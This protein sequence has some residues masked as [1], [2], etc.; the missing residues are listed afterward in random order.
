[1]KIIRETAGELA[2]QE[3]GVLSKIVG[4]VLMAGGVGALIFTSAQWWI[5]G[6][7]ALFG[8]AVLLLG[9]V[10]VI[11]FNKGDQKII[12]ERKSL[13]RASHDE[14]NFG[15]VQ[16]FFIQERR[17]AP[18]RTTGRMTVTYRLV[19]I[20]SAGAD[21]EIGSYTDSSGMLGPLRVLDIAHKLSAFTGIRLE[22]YRQGSMINPLDAFNAV[23]AGIDASI[24]KAREENAQ[25]EKPQQ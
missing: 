10:S 14:Y 7:F 12:V 2:I 4:I 8:L 5:S 23:K 21:I 6:L 3:G 17:G 1:M 9:Q 20:T 19:F 15:A 13:I 18:D 24:A 11:T 16:Y 22:D 25:Q